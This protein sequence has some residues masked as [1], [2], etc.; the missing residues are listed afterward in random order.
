MFFSHRKSKMQVFN[1]K[2]EVLAI[3]ISDQI[4]NT[5]KFYLIVFFKALEGLDYHWVGF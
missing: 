1:K 2:F 3:L 5:F 4:V